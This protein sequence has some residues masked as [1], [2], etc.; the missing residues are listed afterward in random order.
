MDCAMIAFRGMTPSNFVHIPK[1]QNNISSKRHFPEHRVLLFDGFSAPCHVFC[2]IKLEYVISNSIQCDDNLLL[3]YESVSGDKSK[4]LTQNELLL[5]KGMEDMKSLKL[6][7]RKELQ[8]ERNKHRTELQNMKVR[9]PTHITNVCSSTF[10]HPSALSFPHTT[11]TVHITITYFLHFW[12]ISFIYF[13]SKITKAALSQEIR[14]RLEFSNFQNNFIQFPQTLSSPF[15]KSTAL[16]SQ[17]LL[18]YPEFGV[19]KILAAWTMFSW[20]IMSMYVF[21]H[22]HTFLHSVTQCVFLLQREFFEKIKRKE[23]CITTS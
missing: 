8:E 17:F 2:N 10:T 13:A 4:L 23:K 12:S 16:N 11:Y 20:K 21:T 1:V 19:K 22:T 14:A 5:Q 6:K 3:K 18:K 9:F 7:M 15:S